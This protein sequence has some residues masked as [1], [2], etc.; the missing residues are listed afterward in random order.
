MSSESSRSRGVIDRAASALEQ[1]LAR[2][3]ARF[4][5]EWTLE[6]R[7]LE[8]ERRLAVVELIRAQDQIAR[9]HREFE[10]WLADCRA[11]KIELRGE[12]GERGASGA[13]GPPGE[14]GREG[15]DGLPGVPGPDGRDGKNGLDGKDGRDGLGFDDMEEEILDGGRVLIRRYR[16]GERVKEFRHV[17]ATMIYRGPYEHGMQYARGDVVTYGGSMFVAKRETAIKPE[18][19]DWQLAVKKGLPGMRGKDGERGPPG[20]S[21]RDGRDLTSMTLEGMKY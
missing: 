6:F 14:P 5:E 15:R 18:T 3:V 12:P 7:T 10:E 4:R 9:V 1:A 11:Q 20:P 2:I 17:L 21:G 13:Q 19:D 8:T 16:Q